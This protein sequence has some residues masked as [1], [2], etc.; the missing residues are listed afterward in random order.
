MRTTGSWYAN[1]SDSTDYL[2]K[3]NCANIREKEVEEEKKR[4]KQ[5]AQDQVLRDILVYMTEPDMR[6]PDLYGGIMF[7]MRLPVMWV[8]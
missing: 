1:S 7:Y 3:T 6:D 8:I 5:K 4:A 2:S